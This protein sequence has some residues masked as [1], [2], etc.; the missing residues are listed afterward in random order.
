MSRS[1]PNEMFHA[2]IAQ[3]RG[4]TPSVSPGPEPANPFGM[5]TSGLITPASDD[6]A[7]TPARPFMRSRQTTPV[8]LD[9]PPTRAMPRLQRKNSR[10]QSQSRPNLRSQDSDSQQDLFQPWHIESNPRCNGGLKNAVNSVDSK[11][12]KKLWIG[13]LGESTD[14]YGEALKKDIDT[15]MMDE[16]S[17]QPVWIPD[18]E[19]ESCYDEFCHNV[20]S[21]LCLPISC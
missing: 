9:H 6:Y 7:Q 13:T 20:C 1:F 12:K 5:P 10:S 16:C 19:F 11:L 15:R 18:A 2:N 8:G 3:S 21:P 17:S 4:V 14:A